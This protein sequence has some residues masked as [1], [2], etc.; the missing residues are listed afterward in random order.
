MKLKL[1]VLLGV[2]LIALP[3]NAAEKSELKTPK[4]KLDYAIGVD[5][6]R[7]MKK[8]GVQ[9]SVDTMAKGL[10][11]GFSERKALMSDEEIR[12]VIAD[13][14]TEIKL[15]LAEKT[16]LAAQGNKKQGDAFRDENQKKE[17]VVTLPSGL[18][19]KILKAG[20][21]N[22][23]TEADTVVCNYTGKFID[24]NEFDSSY[25][26]G[27]PNKFK[28]DGGIIRGLREALLLMPIGSKWEVVVPPELAYGERGGPAKVGPN[29]TLI[30]DLELVSIHQPGTLEPEKSQ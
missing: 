29:A 24:G 3:V 13:Y 10:K 26:R 28:M 5:I 23:P 9:V 25:K 30:F 11:D 15:K 8:L 1:S 22:K 20:E 2:L 21:G 6:A 14:Q 4:E 19:Y 27:E 16:K 7:N 18:Q 17:G 12:Q